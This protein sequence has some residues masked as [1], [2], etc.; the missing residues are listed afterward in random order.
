[1]NPLVRG[2]SDERFARVIPYKM[3]AAH[4]VAARFAEAPPRRPRAV[5]FPA[6]CTCSDLVPHAALVEPYGERWSVGWGLARTDRAV[7]DLPIGFG[8]YWL[9]RRRAT[10]WL[11]PRWSSHNCD[12]LLLACWS[13]RRGGPCPAGCKQQARMS[14][15]IKRDCVK[16]IVT[17]DFGDLREGLHVPSA[18]EFVAGQRALPLPLVKGVSG[19]RQGQSPWFYGTVASTCLMATKQPRDAS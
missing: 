16:I 4:E 1:M 5:Q 9:N 12:G 13:S 11:R 2:A 8:R 3:E 17:H 19:S 14:A 7:D 18:A 6:E 10:G 15:Q